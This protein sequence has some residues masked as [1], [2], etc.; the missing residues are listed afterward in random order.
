CSRARGW[1]EPRARSAAGEPGLAL[2]DERPHA[3]LRVVAGEERAEELGLRA[4]VRVVLALERGVDGLLGRAQRERA[5]RRERPR[6]FERLLEHGVVDPAH[7]PALQRL[8]RV[9]EAPRE[10]ELL[11]EADSAHA[12]EPLRAAP[13]GDDPEVDLRLAELGLRRRVAQVAGKRELAAA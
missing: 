5:F 1:S 8:V 11:C 13:A 7:E 10:D 4:E 9:D 3:L 2:L 6:G 12:R